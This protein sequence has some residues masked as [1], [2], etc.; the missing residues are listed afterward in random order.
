MKLTFRSK[1]FLTLLFNSLVVVIG[2]LLIAGFYAAR[3]FERYVVKV[4]ER[5]VNGLLEL[6]G[7][8]YELAGDWAPLRE[9]VGQWLLILG[10]RPGRP[11]E[12]TGGAEESARNGAGVSETEGGRRARPRYV[13]F[14]RNRHALSPTDSV[15]ADGYD[16]KAVRAGGKVVGWL[17]VHER[18]RPSQPLDVEFLRHQASTFR[19]V[20]GVAV[21]VAIVVTWA[22]SRHLLAPV[23]ELV[24]GTRALMSRRFETRVEVGSDDEFGRLAS[25]FNEMARTLERYERMRRQWLADIAH[26]LRTPL[27]VLRGEIEAMLDGVR[28]VNREA[29]ESLHG[30]VLHLSRIVHDLHDLSLIESG[31]FQAELKPVDPLGVLDETLKAFRTRFDQRGM[32]IRAPDF[33]RE[34]PVHVRADPD[35]LR[36]L[37]SN[38]LEN[39]LRYGEAP[40]W[41]EIGV[42]TDPGRVVIHLEDSGPGVPEEC[43]D[44]LFDRLYRVD[45]ARS[46]AQGGSGLG[47]AICRSIVESVG[48]RIGAARGTSGGLRITVEFPRL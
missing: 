21:V 2:M 18:P 41:I 38:I 26:E 20:G 25:D 24:K 14:D 40:G 46:R 31:R 11:H 17:G 7:R 15:S 9:S 4:E 32:E 27:A 23:Q 30:E 28:D 39:T 10:M 35:R 16:L 6:L 43:L 5:K 44:R 33:A 48:G 3:N 42:E 8:E 36:Q 13:L 37:F 1:V 22:L 19:A 47:L 34:A 12:E 45:R 29:L